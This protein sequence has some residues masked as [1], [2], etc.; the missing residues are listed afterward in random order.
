MKL[1]YID[2]YSKSCFFKRKYK[3]FTFE[4]GNELYV[5]SQTKK[6]TKTIEKTGAQMIVENCDKDFLNHLYIKIINKC[7]KEQNL[8]DITFSF[9]N[10]ADYIPLLT[11]FIK[12]DITFSLA[13]SQGSQDT[14]SFFLEECGLPVA[15]TQ[16]VKS[17]LYVYFGGNKIRCENSAV[18]LDIEKSINSDY[19]I[20]DCLFPIRISSPSLLY[21]ALLL[22]GKSL[23]DIITKPCI[24][25]PDDE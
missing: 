17:G 7:M 18:I 11:H 8:K 21:A 14:A 16:R 12:N 24:I 1:G 22:T 23:D 2:A 4:T 10:S 9:Y 13:D 19:L 3:I 25:R 5:F 20:K 6:I 15:V